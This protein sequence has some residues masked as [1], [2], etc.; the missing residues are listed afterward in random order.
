MAAISR[1]VPVTISEHIGSWIRRTRL[2]AG[3]TQI[4]LSAKLGTS[5]GGLSAWERGDVAPRTDD[6]VAVCHALRAE[7]GHALQSIAIAYTHATPLFAAAV[8]A[9]G[10]K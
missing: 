9:K 1:R 8:P 5:Q 3:H 10:G 7:P 2:A 4:S 6:F